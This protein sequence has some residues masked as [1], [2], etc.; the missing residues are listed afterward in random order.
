ML[1]KKQVIQTWR[2]QLKTQQAALESY[3]FETP[4]NY[5]KNNPTLSTHA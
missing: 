5:S 1:D 2:E 3:F 4:H